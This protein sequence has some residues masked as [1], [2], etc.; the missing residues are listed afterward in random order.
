[1]YATSCTTV[2]YWMMC[3]DDYW[4]MCYKLKSEIHCA[5]LYGAANTVLRHV[6][7]VTS[8]TLSNLIHILI[9]NSIGIP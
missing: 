3:Y 9:V 4:M 7:L 8:L 6:L 1:M 2:I 5:I